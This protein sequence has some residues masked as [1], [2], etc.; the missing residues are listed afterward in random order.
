M[1]WWGAPK[2][3]LIFQEQIQAQLESLR[4]EKGELEERERKERW[5]CQDYLVGAW[6]YWEEVHLGR[7][8]QGWFLALSWEVELRCPAVGAR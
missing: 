5:I 1:G 8:K 7:V 6:C 4:R 3:S 2:R